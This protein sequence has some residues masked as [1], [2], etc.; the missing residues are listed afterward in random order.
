MYSGMR[1]RTFEVLL[2]VSSALR[3]VADGWPAGLLSRPFSSLGF[4]GCLFLATCALR[5]RPKS[6]YVARRKAGSCS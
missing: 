4:A 1:R 6:W 5:V 3:E 2:L